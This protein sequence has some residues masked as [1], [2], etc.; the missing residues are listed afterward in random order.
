MAEVWGDGAAWRLDGG[1]HPHE[2]TYLKLDCSKAKALLDWHPR[3]DLATALEQIVHW[4]RA[5]N[6][7]EDM[8]A[9]TLQ[10]ISHYTSA[11]GTTR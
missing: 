3:W 11:A 5:F 10:Q 7:G 1:Q 9:L 8:R 6:R 4:Y 2:A